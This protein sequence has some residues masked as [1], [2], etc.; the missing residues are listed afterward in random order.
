VKSGGCPLSRGSFPAKLAL[1]GP[2]S[3]Q[4][5]EVST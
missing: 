5:R 2:A 4:N 1:E 3:V